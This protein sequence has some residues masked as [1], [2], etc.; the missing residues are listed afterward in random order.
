MAVPVTIR[1]L[2]PGGTWMV[3]GREGTIGIEPEN[4]SATSNEHGPDTLTFKLARRSKLPANDLY[5]FTRIEMDA[6]GVGNVWAGFVWATSYGEDD[7]VSVT[8][9]GTQYYMDLDQLQRRWIHDRVTDWTDQSQV[10]GSGTDSTPGTMAATGASAGGAIVGFQNTGTAAAAIGAGTNST[11]FLDFGQGIDTAASIGFTVDTIVGANANAVLHA[12]SHDHLEWNA[13]SFTD[14]TSTAMTS[15]AAGNT[16]VYT[17]SPGYRYVSLILNVNAGFNVPAGGTWMRLSN[18]IVARNTGYIS[19]GASALLAST[20]F[21]DVLGSSALPSSII[22][23]GDTSQIATTAFDIPH[24]DTGGTYQ[25]PRQIFDACNAY[26]D[27]LYGIDE[28]Y[29]LFFQARPTTPLIEVGQWS[30]DAFADAGDAAEELYNKAVVSATDANGNQI[31][32]A[33]TNS[34]SLLTA[35]GL[36]RTM[37]LQASAAL[38]PAAASQL[39]AAWLTR[40]AARP[41]QGTISFSGPSACRYISDGLPVKPA[42]CLRYYGQMIRLADRW[43]PDDGGMGRDAYITACTWSADDDKTTLTLDAPK[44]RLEVVLSRFAALQSAAPLNY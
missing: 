41:T 43:N 35:A 38:T 4:V 30:G 13:G 44:D 39:G 14:G 37:N 36:T 33:S 12:R 25:T 16:Y 3:L 6:S 5:P 24:M 11:V 22:A 18:I 8:C 26:H 10:V 23:T 42:E 27:Y 19:G 2:P 17:V 1:V 7:S 20:V 34:S 9:R 21:A 28:Q 31:N 29:R 32:V 15:Y 40:R